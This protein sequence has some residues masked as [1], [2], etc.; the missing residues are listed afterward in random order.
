MYLV[1]QGDSCGKLIKQRGM[2]PFAE[3]AGPFGHVVAKPYARCALVRPN[4][5]M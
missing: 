1:T 3:A 5:S 4:I 2:G